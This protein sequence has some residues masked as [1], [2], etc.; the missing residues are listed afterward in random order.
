MY[1]YVSCSPEVSVFVLLYSSKTSKRRSPRTK[2]PKDLSG[3]ESEDRGRGESVGL[4]VV[5]LRE[6][7]GLGRGGSVKNCCIMNR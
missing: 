5:Y 3:H 4:Y 1:S 6:R 7:G 2:T